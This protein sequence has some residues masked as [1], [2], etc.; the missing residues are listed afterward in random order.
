[1]KKPL[2]F[3]Q[4]NL[5]EVEECL[6]YHL[7][8][9]RNENL[10]ISSAFKLIVSYAR[11]GTD[12]LFYEVLERRARRV[13]VSKSTLKKVIA[14]CPNLFVENEGQVTCTAVTDSVNYADKK[15]KI[16]QKG[17]KAKAA[18]AVLKQSVSRHTLTDNQQVKSK[19]IAENLQ[20]PCILCGD[21][22][23]SEDGFCGID[24]RE[25]W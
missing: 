19:K 23:E 25:S 18:S 11:T 15:F 1:M 13:G 22:H 12:T 5:L 8:G 21:P 24:C 14:A 7:E 3:L 16:A 10:L 20:K 2:N 6:F 17:G 9:E 4:L